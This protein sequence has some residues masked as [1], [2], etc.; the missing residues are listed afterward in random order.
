MRASVTALGTAVMRLVHTRFD[1]SPLID[2][3]WAERLVTDHERTMLREAGIRGVSA[4]T[5]T[6]LEKLPEDEIMAAL[7]RAHP[8]YA[9]VILRSRYAEDVFAQAVGRG[10]RQYVIVGAGMDSFALRAPS[11]AQDVEV[12]EIDHPASQRLKLDRMRDR[13]IE[14]SMPV[15][16]VATD[17][18]EESLDAALARS[19]FDPNRASFFSWLGVTAYLTREANLS[20]LGA[21]ARCGGHG[22]ELVFSYQDQRAFDSPDEER[23][24]VLAVVG[25]LGE[26]WVSGFHPSQLAE[27]LRS[28]GLALVEDLGREALHERYCSDRDDGLSVS[29]VDHIA[30]AKID[31]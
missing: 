24:R 7:A 9:A 31:A 19:P 27:D 18:G 26:P 15:H 25:A 20:T 6:K 23:R 5:R 16:Y 3:V 22:S 13:G 4:V 11:F 29:V 2:D 21:I 14:P 17:L 10:A 1:Q 12:F 30:H 8:S 28:V